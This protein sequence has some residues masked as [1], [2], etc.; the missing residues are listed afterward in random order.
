MS[1]SF[2]EERTGSSSIQVAINQQTQLSYF[3]KSD[4]QEDITKE[5]VEA[6]ANSKYRTNDHFLNWVKTVF[7]TDNFLTFFKYLRFPIAS[8][9]LINERIKTPLSRV[10][11][12]E[13]AY[14]NYVVNSENVE[15]PNNLDVI[16][17][18]DQLFNALLFN[19]NDIVIHDLKDINT[20]TREIVSINNVVSLDS[21]NSVIN[22]IAYT[23]VI[24]H[25][26]QEEKGI[27][28]IDNEKYCFFKSGI[29]TP[30]VTIE[31]DLGECP[32]DYISKEAFGSDDIV[33]KSIF[34]YSRESLEEYCFLK[35]LQRMSEPNGAI[36]VVTMLDAK[37]NTKDDINSSDKEPMSSKEMGGQRSEIHS[38]VNGSNSL[39]QTG[40][41]IKVPIVKKTDGSVDMEM[42]K[43]FLNFHH[44]PTESLR[45]ID[46]RINEIEQ[47]IIV[48]LCGDFSE[49]NESAKNELQVSR[50]FVSKQDKLRE[51]SLQLSRIRERSDFK[52]L[53]LEYGRDNVSVDAFYGS[54]FF[55]ESQRE[56]YEL[57]E[58]SPNPIER[59]NIALR[60]AK[61]RSRF[62]PTKADRDVL[63]NKLLPYSSD[64]DFDKAITRNILDDV[65]FQYQTRFDYWIDIF[66]ANYGDI[67]EFYNLM[68]GTESE[69]LVLINNLIIEGIKSAPIREEE[70][71]TNTHT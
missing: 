55:L 20:P 66:Q 69:K 35:T 2:I 13:D 37:R 42:A 68:E 54:D 51:L 33:R 34:S 29:D 53:A 11:Y 52:M 24:T 32:A 71:Q 6:W 58:K 44:A 65:T 25:E 50:S 61:N 26:G 38:G 63:L 39:L 48:S 64:E 46:D 60:L 47:M 62:N 4:I 10:F 8:A 12:S 49:A 18:N 14:F 23:A 1:I 21:K 57:F 70:K 16:N 56:L 67:L 28:Y 45:F 22:R 3:T 27:I 9:R 41:E 36:P 40:T 43:S 59:K 17:F 7:R 31:H 19:H 30:L 15:C 5:Y